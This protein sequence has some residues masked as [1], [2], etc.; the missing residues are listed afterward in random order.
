[1]LRLAAAGVPVTNYGL[2]L[3]WY[4]GPAALRRV[5]APWRG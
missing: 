1:V 2:A 3:A 4:E 5:L